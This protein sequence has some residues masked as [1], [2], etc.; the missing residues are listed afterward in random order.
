MFANNVMHLVVNVMEVLP[1][2]V[3]FVVKPNIYKE[4]NV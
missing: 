3:L 2:I 1:K 4:G